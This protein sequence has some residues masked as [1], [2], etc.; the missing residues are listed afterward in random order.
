MAEPYDIVVASP[1]ANYDF[2]AHKMREL[3][4]QWSLGFFMVDDVWVKEFLQKLQSREI[5]VRVL[6]DLTANQVLEDDLYLQLAREVK[7][8][9]GHVIDDP[10]ITAGV[11]HKAR[12]H[13]VLLQHRIPVPETVMVQRSELDSFRLTD[14]IKAEVG[15]PFVV[16]P[17]WGDSGV[18][19]IVDGYSEDD[20]RESATLA[21]NSDTFLIQK[22]LS[23]KQLG[24]HVSWFRT[25]HICGE[26]IPCW[27]DPLSHE[28][29]LVSPAQVKRYKLQP[30][31]R[32]VRGIAR[33]SRMKK[34]SS[35]ICLH[36]DGKFYAVDYVNADPDMNPKSFYNNGVP[37]EVVRHIVWLL[38]H[39]AMR[40]VKKGHGFF[41]EYLN[42]AEEGSNWLEQR[43]IEQRA[44]VK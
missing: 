14:D 34:F 26:V 27:W 21:P 10:D 12:F 22:R 33:A 41:D 29:H 25:F 17:A 23:T 3:C 40:L 38:F 4:G 43:K 30:L 2:F 24:N 35:E 42:E 31:Q 28:Y 8:Q 1:F 18:G 7:R 5:S 16:K 36:Q 20:L 32:I 44:Q 6:F 39:E 37:D 19:V 11:A 13:R 15:V 9:S